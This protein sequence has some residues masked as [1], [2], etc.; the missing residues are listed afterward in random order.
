MAEGDSRQVRGLKQ[1]FPDRVAIFTLD[2]A[3]SARRGA[4]FDQAVVI[5]YDQIG[6]RTWRCSAASCV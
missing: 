4:R 2:P 6:R 1:L 3:S 5:G